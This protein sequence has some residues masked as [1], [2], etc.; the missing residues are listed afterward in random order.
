MLKKF[1][2]LTLASLLSF[3]LYGCSL[4]D[5]SLDT[6]ESEVGEEEVLPVVPEEDADPYS[7]QFL[8]NGVS[9]LDLLDQ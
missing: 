6:V 3:S 4:F 2:T 8:E 1:S 7:T 9:E 5:S